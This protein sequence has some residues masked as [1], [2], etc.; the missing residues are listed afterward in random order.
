MDRLVSM[1][2]FVKAVDLGSFAAAAEQ[3]GISATMVGKHVQF[4]EN[5]LGVS[6]LNRTTRRQNLTE[7]G[8]AYYE[9]CRL[10]LDE[11]AAA[12]AL[13]SDHLNVP[14][15]TLRVTMPALL[16]RVC[17][18]PV[19]REL[20]TRH[21]TLRLELSLTDRVSELVTGGFDLSVRT[22]HVE[23]R[24]GLIIRRLGSH[25]MVVCASPGYLEAHG[26]PGN[27]E[28]LSSHVSVMYARP[29][30][31]HAWLFRDEAGN[32]IEIE[33]PHRIRLDDLAAVADAAIDDAGLAWLPS[34]LA[35][36]HLSAGTLVEVLSNQPSYSF[37]NY[38]VWPHTKLLPLRVRVALD[39]LAEQ[40]PGRLDGGRKS[41]LGRIESC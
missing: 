14:R 30:W 39:L 36:P 11:A 16:G 13:A 4:L 17:V 26:R 10:I 37:D 2:V 38:A 31:A 6:L 15:G 20:I 21:P 29:G 7:F 28:S 5:R 1:G 8:R 41:G 18:A 34:W 40:L 24:A 9:R 19:L 23:D 3:T 27:L 25:R 33:P 35:G 32:L 12:D 22:G